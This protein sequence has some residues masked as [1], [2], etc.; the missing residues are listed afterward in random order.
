V[1]LLRPKESTAEAIAAVGPLFEEAAQRYVPI[2]RLARLSPL[3]AELV[4]LGAKVPDEQR[5]SANSI[6]TVSLIAG[7]ADALEADTP[8]VFARSGAERPSKKTF[9]ALVTA[10]LFERTYP[11]G[12]SMANKYFGGP[13]RPATYLTEFQKHEKSAK[14][15]LKRA[16]WTSLQQDLKGI[17]G[18][19][20]DV[21]GK[22]SLQPDERAAYHLLRSFFAL[23]D[24]IP[25]MRSEEPGRNHRDLVAHAFGIVRTFAEIRRLAR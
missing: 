21:P 18:A 11:L 14:A 23:A 9:C 10:Q 25:M 4:P 20:E 12:S 22:L 2:D 8:G 6:G 13:P 3:A 24:K 1:F 16:D 7:I 19:C 5:R 17:A 15:V